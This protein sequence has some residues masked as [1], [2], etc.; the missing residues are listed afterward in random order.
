MVLHHRW[1]KKPDATE[2][3]PPILHYLAC[4]C[5]SPDIFQTLI[6]SPLVWSALTVLQALG[7]LNSFWN[8]LPCL[9]YLGTSCYL[10]SSAKTTSVKPYLTP[11]FN[12]QHRHTSLRPSAL[13]S[14]FI[15][16]AFLQCPIQDEW[17]KIKYLP[18]NESHE[19]SVY[20]LLGDS[21]HVWNIFVSLKTLCCEHIGNWDNDV[22]GIKVIIM[23]E[24]SF[25]SLVNL[26]GLSFLL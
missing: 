25:T 14:T 18:S 2:T 6:P 3:S 8:A 9:V 19:F 13:P 26:S 17:N 24:T 5:G 1:F 15:W 21:G 20:R 16:E 10:H 7:T 12:F 23:D 22:F 4:V 11:S